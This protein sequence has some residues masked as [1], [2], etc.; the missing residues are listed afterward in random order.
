VHHGTPPE[1][2]G[3]LAAVPCRP[4]GVGVLAACRTPRR[5][6]GGAPRQPCGPAGLRVLPCPRKAVGRQPPRHLC[7]GPDG[8]AD[9]IPGS[10]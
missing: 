3:C 6:P 4:D 8:P 7:R 2:A 9:R 10:V 1:R 5:R